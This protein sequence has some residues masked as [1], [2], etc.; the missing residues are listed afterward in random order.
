MRLELIGHV[1]LLVH[2]YFFL[3]GAVVGGNVKAIGATTGAC[4]GCNDGAL[5]GGRLGALVG[6]FVEIRLHC[7]LVSSLT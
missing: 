5:V 1:K 4:V 6:V 2:T 3:V 7:F